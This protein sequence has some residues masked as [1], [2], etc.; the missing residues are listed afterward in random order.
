MWILLWLGFSVWQIEHEWRFITCWI[1]PSQQ[2]LSFIRPHTTSQAYFPTYKT[3]WRKLTERGSL[4]ILKNKSSL[5]YVYNVHVQRK[6]MEIYLREEFLPVWNIF[7]IMRAVAASQASSSPLLIIYTLQTEKK[8]KQHRFH[9]PYSDE[10]C[11][12]IFLNIFS[13]I[14]CHINLLY[15]LTELKL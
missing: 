15:I 8:G 4:K 12:N 5:I 14:S 13:N 1:F 7:S 3:S 2:I 9:F 10:Q 6:A 11:L